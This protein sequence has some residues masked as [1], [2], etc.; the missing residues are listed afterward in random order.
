MNEA[1]EENIPLDKV[2]AEPYSL[3]Q[4]FRWA[5]VDLS[6][7]AQLQELYSLLTKNYVEDD[8]SMFRFDYSPEFLK[9]ALQVP[10]YLPEWHCGVRAENNNRLLAFIGAVP[11]T[12]RVY[13]KTVK[14]VEINFLCVHKNLRSRR[15]APVLIREITRRVNQQGIFQVNLKIGKTLNSS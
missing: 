6:D 15:V 9:W 3:P 4:G 5:N 12:I 8:D 13:D 7:P 2:R 11:Q 1:I 14:M 10:N